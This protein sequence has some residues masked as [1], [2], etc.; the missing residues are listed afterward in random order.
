MKKMKSTVGD[1]DFSFL[2]KSNDLNNS[3]EHYENKG[4]KRTIQNLFSSTGQAKRP[5][6]ESS[7][8]ANR[9]DYRT[10]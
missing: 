4:P 2:K 7:K 3:F 10:T 9:T 5:K 1:F 6:L 8:S